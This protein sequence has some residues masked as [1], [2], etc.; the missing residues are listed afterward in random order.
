M[1]IIFLC[2]GIPGFYGT[3]PTHSSWHDFYLFPTY[4]CDIVLAESV[5]SILGL[6]LYIVTGF[7]LS[8]VAVMYRSA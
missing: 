3:H 1:F 2:A 7:Y 8:C 4:V 5:S 6:G